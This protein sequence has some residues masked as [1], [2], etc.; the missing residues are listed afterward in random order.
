MNYVVCK[1]CL[2]KA[3]Q[4]LRAST[5]LQSR[6]R[7]NAAG[8][9]VRAE[10]GLMKAGLKM[11]HLGSLSRRWPGSRPGRR[12][13]AASHGGSHGVGRAASRHPGSGDRGP[14]LQRRS[15][16]RSWPWLGGGHACLMG[17]A[18]SRLLSWSPS[19]REAGALQGLQ[20]LGWG[21]SAGALSFV[22]LPPSLKLGH[23]QGPSR[24]PLRSPREGSG[25]HCR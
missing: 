4:T 19:F 12:Q 15:A 5:A 9:G 18:P 21:R 13:A 3:R 20:A 23:R 2:N 6:S 24:V 22:T 14:A 16:G 1:S 25:R 8:H 7:Q 11:V 10:A 17:H